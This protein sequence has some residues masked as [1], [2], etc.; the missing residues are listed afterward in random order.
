MAAD[1]KIR[2]ALRKGSGFRGCLGF[3]HQG[4]RGEPATQAEAQNGSIHST[5][6]AKVV[7]VHN[8]SF[9]SEK[10]INLGMAPDAAGQLHEENLGWA[11]TDRPGLR[12]SE[13]SFSIL[14][15]G[16]WPGLV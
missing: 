13:S 9:H 6:Q 16:R 1:A 10:C 5:G 15:P 12:P 2:S 4:R 8:E 14:N 11:G 3:G 7:G